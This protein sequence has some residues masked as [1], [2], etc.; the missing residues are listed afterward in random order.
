M[1]REAEA[2]GSVA[3]PGR[4]P[5][6]QTIRM[7]R[8]RKLEQLGL[9][10]RAGGNRWVLA[11]DLAGTLRRMG[12]RGDLVRTMQRALAERGQGAP[13]ADLAIYDPAEGRTDPLVG[14]VLERG[15][16]DEHADRHYLLIEAID[17]RTHYVDI[18]TASLEEVRRGSIVRA[19]PVRVAVRQS[20]RTV[21]EVA[22]ANGGRYDVDTHL[23]HDRNA[24]EAFA[25]THVRRL[26]A[27]RRLTGAVERE[28]DGTW[29]IAPDHLTRALAYE[30][31]RT[32]DRPVRLEQL[33][34]SPLDH[35]VEAD[36]ATWLDEELTG[37]KPLPLRETGFGE[38]VR[39]ALERRRQWLLHEE[40]A[41]DRDGKVVYRPD[42]IK[43]LRR[44]ELLRIAESL[45]G[46][47]GVE[48]V[49][50]KSGERVEGIFRRAVAATNGR[51]ALIERSRD[52]TLVPW[53]P[54]L[55]PHVGRRMSGVLRGGGMNW[56]IGRGR[57]GPGIS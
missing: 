56:T 39:G 7:G 54:M 12:E 31:A 33:S 52:F 38:E 6:E 23:R 26:E 53:R 18:G 36:A 4:T 24:T 41:E 43:L 34:A 29:I 40:L 11:A 3:A 21:A 16:S 47:L 9:A 32:R 14:R 15:L 27:I 2:Q 19:D 51:Y 28:P 46:E 25:Q 37:P 30:A 45:S 22:A 44:R 10:H 1:I 35:L 8:L 49:E 20:D 42:L 55:E 5:F 48:F 57:S 17:G 50:T 13:A